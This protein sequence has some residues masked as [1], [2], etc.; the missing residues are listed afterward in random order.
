ME[1]Y[2][3]Q[4]LIGVCDQLLKEG[5]KGT[6]ELTNSYPTGVKN[7]FGDQMVLSLSG[8]CKETLYLAA[9]PH[10]EERI[11]AGRYEV[12]SRSISSF[13]VE[14]LVDMAWN[15]YQ[16]YK[17]TAPYSIQSEWLDLYIKYGYVKEKIT[18]VYEELK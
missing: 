6:I 17:N 13:T 4:D 7:I 10:D 1:V 16:K 5:Y 14:L 3:P 9:D 12:L 15:M 8:F 2:I 11:A 18:T